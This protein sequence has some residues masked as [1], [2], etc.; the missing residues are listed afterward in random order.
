MM[1]PDRYFGHCESPKDQDDLRKL[2][3]ARDNALPLL[4]EEARSYHDAIADL[5]CWFDGFRAGRG[6][7]YSEP[8][9]LDTLRELKL[10]LR[11][12]FDAS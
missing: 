12:R 2:A 1:D 9:G 11:Y 10:R 7:S 5:L 3:E 4:P 8:L 6:D